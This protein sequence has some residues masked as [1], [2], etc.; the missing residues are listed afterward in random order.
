MENK[1]KSIE[2]DVWRLMEFGEKHTYLPEAFYHILGKRLLH[3]GYVDGQDAEF[4]KQFEEEMIKDEVVNNT[5]EFVDE[6]IEED[7][8]SL[9]DETFDENEDEEVNEIETDIEK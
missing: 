8:I 7:D 6:F 5:E 9:E 3:Q 1:R 2:E 4:E